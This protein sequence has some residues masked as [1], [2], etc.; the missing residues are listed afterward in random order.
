MVIDCHTHV[1]PPWIAPDRA[2][3]LA[4]DA[5]FK[6][7]YTSPNAKLA[8]AEDLI[9]SMDRDGI[10][11]SVAVNLSWRSHELCGRTN[12]YIMESV[13]RYPQRLIGFGTVDLSSTSAALREVERCA[14]GG[15]KGI[16]E[17]RLDPASIESPPLAECL[18]AIAER[19]LLLL[20]HA[21]EPVGHQYAGKGGL[22]PERLYPMI[23]RFPKLRIMAAHWG[24]GL[25]F[26]ALMPEV[27]AALGNV[28]FDT[29]ASPFLYRTDVYRQAIE[30]I[31]ADHILFG[32][33]FPLLGQGRV[34]K[35]IRSQGLPADQ[36]RLILGGNAAR[37]LG[38]TE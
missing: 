9:T 2:K 34:L 31:G 21:S 10:D 23:A 19:G 13:A 26:Y 16:G 18:T 15:L 32:S 8:T 38:L 22:T 4:A 25:P 30:L 20:V 17:M 11:T 1:F 36:E 28:Y 35:E 5:V 33:D 6:E 3:Y 27:Q 29:A 24:G 37:L 12:D 7:L 14:R